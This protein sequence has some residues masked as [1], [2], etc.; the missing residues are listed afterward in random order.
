MI[1]HWIVAV[2]WNGKQAVK[3]MIYRQLLSAVEEEDCYCEIVFEDSE[4]WDAIRE[5]VN[6]PVKTKKSCAVVSKNKALA[7]DAAEVMQTYLN[8]W[9]VH[10]VDDVK[11]NDYSYEDA[12]FV[13][14]C[15]CDEMLILPPKKGAKKKIFWL[16]E[17]FFMENEAKTSIVN[18]IGEKMNELG[19]DIFDYHN[20]TYISSIECE[21][22]FVKIYREEITPMALMLK[23]DFVMWDDYGLPVSFSR[24]SSENIQL[25]L[26]SNCR[27]SDM[28]CQLSAKRKNNE[29]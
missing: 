15:S 21:M 10:P 8:D 29:G 23:D 5:A 27:F 25:F 17:P 2:L 16:N 24:M 18:E 11:N 9:I 1:T 13:V 22:A 26:E 20:I 4:R 7:Q 12:V 19:W 28:A 6:R 3:D 14:G